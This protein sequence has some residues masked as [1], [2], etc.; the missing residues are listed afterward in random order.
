MANLGDNFVAL[1]HVTLL[2]DQ[3]DN[4]HAAMEDAGREIREGIHL[5]LSS[6]R[7]VVLIAMNRP[8]RQRLLST[9]LE[10]II[11]SNHV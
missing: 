8:C 3:L 11:S 10:K 9:G 6:C 7:C 1:Q 4:V 5:L 2:E